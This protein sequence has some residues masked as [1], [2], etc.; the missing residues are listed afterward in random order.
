MLSCAAFVA[1][2]ETLRMPGSRTLFPIRGG[3]LAKE[4]SGNI[5]QCTCLPSCDCI[6]PPF[7]H[8]PLPSFT[9]TLPSFLAQTHAIKSKMAQQQ[10][11]SVHELNPAYHTHIAIQNNIFASTVMSAALSDTINAQTFSSAQSPTLEWPA[12]RRRPPRSGS[13]RLQP[14]RD[15]HADAARLWSAAVIGV[16]R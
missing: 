11:V 5:T 6:P 14:C 7:I 8:L 13:R 10:D 1:H 12:C 2:A 16:L 9:F 3:R 4:N 15:C